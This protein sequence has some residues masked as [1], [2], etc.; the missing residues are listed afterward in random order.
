MTTRNC[1]I[2]SWRY[3]YPAK[4]TVLQL[5]ERFSAEDTFIQL[6]EQFFSQLKGYATW[7]RYQD[8]Q[9]KSKL[10]WTEE[11]YFVDPCNSVHKIIYNKMCLV[12]IYST[13]SLPVYLFLC[14]SPV[15]VPPLTV[16]W[17]SLPVLAGSLY[18][19][20]HTDL[21]IAFPTIERCVLPNVCGHYLESSVLDT[22]SCHQGNNFHKMLGHYIFP[23]SY[24]YSS[25]LICHSFFTFLKVWPVI[26]DLCDLLIYC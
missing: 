17:N 23:G 9:L 11:I 4:W 3:L 8:S 2:F 5:A 22:C 24:P 20:C 10:W 12:S 19:C 1:G 26:S 16:P 6:N 14:N 18:I 21:Y 25:C 7:H 13:I 15:M